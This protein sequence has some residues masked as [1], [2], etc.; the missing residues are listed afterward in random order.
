MS[1]SNNISLAPDYTNT[2]IEKKILNC[3]PRINK[4]GEILQ[5]SIIGSKDYYIQKQI[6]NANNL[7]PIQPS[8][9][10]INTPNSHNFKPQHSKQHSRKNF[11][12][13]NILGETSPTAVSKKYD[14]FSQ[15]KHKDY[16]QT[17]DLSD[18]ELARVLENINNRKQNETS[19]L[20]NGQK[21]SL[22]AV[23][24]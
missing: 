4:N 3:S 13:L 23:L 6:T 14:F 10:A 8:H 19:L 9:T 15:K 18:K 5:R 1:N 21:M 20:N 7:A 16:E 12:D 22:N 2:S 11:D 24:E 17:M